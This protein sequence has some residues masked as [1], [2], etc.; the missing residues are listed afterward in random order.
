MSNAMWFFIVTFTT[1]GMRHS[2]ILKRKQITEYI[3]FS[4]YGDVTPATYCGRSKSNF[5]P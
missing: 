4:G 5:Y 1:V 3:L 2:E